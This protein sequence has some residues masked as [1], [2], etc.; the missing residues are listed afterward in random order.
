[1]G[2]FESKEEAPAATPL[3]V[4]VK[5]P[6]GSE[7]PISSWS[8]WSLKDLGREIT[9]AKKINPEYQ[10]LTVEGE[11][12]GRVN[13]LDTLGNQ[14]IPAGAYL[15]LTVDYNVE[16]NL[17]FQVMPPTS[18]RSVLVIVK[19]TDSTEIV[20]QK[21]FDAEGIPIEHQKLQVGSGSFMKDGATLQQCGVDRNCSS[22]RIWVFKLE[23]E[24]KAAANANANATSKNNLAKNNNPL[25]EPLVTTEN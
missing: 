10:V 13:S 20:K 15:T 1:M 11:G 5:C 18:N 17:N 6:D 2:C 14:N 3:S 24:K 7:L 22:M 21:I 12:G 16:F 4:I 8:T 9:V 25:R 19:C 23:A